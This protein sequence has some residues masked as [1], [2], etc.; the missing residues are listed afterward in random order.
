LARA[1]RPLP[2]YK[3]WFTLLVVLVG[4]LAPS[5]ALARPLVIERPGQREFVADYANLLG[6]ED[7]Q[8]IRR[9][10]TELLDEHATPIVVVTIESMA[11]HGGLGMSIESF[12][13]TLF[14]Q[15]GVG[16]PVVNDQHWDTGILFVISKGDRKARIELG[17]GWAH[18]KDA[19]AQLIM[20][21]RIIPAFRAGDYP[22]GTLAGV[23]AL[24]AMARSKSLPEEPRPMSHYL[25]VAVAILL[26]LGVIVS[27][28]KNGRLG[29]G[30][31]LIL[32]VFGILGAFWWVLGR[33]NSSSNGSWG[34]FGGGRSGGGGATGSW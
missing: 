8:A 6:D 26:L 16:H 9:I 4:M 12:A 13:Q 17:S 24:S 2:I 3:L 18:E 31:K 21:N 29:W 23:D 14:D 1:H 20:E 32:L 5:S 11:A 15:W 25:I 7:E 27:L 33:S 19:E 10:A 34:S 30:W 22:R 28:I